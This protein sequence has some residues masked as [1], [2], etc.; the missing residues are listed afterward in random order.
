MGGMS[1]FAAPMAPPMPGM[2]VPPMM[3]P[4][5]AMRAP[6]GT[7]G[8]RP[9]TG[10]LNVSETTANAMNLSVADRPMTQQGL[11]GIRQGT[12]SGARNVLDRNYWITQ[13]QKRLKEVVDEVTA[14]DRH[15]DA[16]YL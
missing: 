16:I 4:G 11:A 3:P 2:G 1:G 5:T 6:P 9:G 13:L 10:K 14:P 15:A 8:M 12:A 7:A